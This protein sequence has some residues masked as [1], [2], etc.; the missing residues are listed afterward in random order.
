MSTP[1]DWRPPALKDREWEYVAGR[2]DILRVAHS[3]LNELDFPDAEVYPADVI[4]AA[5]FL[6]GDTN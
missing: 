1:A 2:L 4:E 6:A 3:A 5:K